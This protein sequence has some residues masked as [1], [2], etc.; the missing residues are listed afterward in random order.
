MKNKILI[1][2]LCIFACTNMRISAQNFE[3]VYESTFP[4]KVVNRNSNIDSEIVVFQL[5]LI[6]R[7]SQVKSSQVK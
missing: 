3:Q 1:V 7:R 5:D 6:L 2:V 4:F